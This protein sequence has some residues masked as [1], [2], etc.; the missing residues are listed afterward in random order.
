MARNYISLYQVYKSYLSLLK[1]EERR[2]DLSLP[3]QCSIL[4][5]QRFKTIAEWFIKYSVSKYLCYSRTNIPL[6]IEDK[7]VQTKL[8]S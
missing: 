5:L 6:S 4:C 3:L 1:Q 7:V 8:M 2:S